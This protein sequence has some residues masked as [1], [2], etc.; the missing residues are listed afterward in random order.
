MVVAIIRRLRAVPAREWPAIAAVA[1]LA[2]V[3]EV[4]LRLLPLT[5]LAGLLGVPVDT[6]SRTTSP[7]AVAHAEPPAWVRRRVRTTGRV[8]RHWPP[9]TTCLRHAL[10]LGHRLRRLGPVLRIG[11]ARI[12]GE[13][14]A[15]AWLEIDGRILDPNGAAGAY[16]ALEALPNTDVA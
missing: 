16:Q 5:R 4:G 6:T 14:Q 9:G 8:M 13:V 7:S 3:V 1:G 11:V 2:G 12:D 10:V 15:H